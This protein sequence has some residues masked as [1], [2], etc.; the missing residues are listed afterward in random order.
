MHDAK[1]A[2]LADVFKRLLCESV[3]SE[4][5]D[6]RILARSILEL[7]GIIVKLRRENDA[8]RNK[9][10]AVNVCPSDY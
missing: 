3:P 9:L 2:A 7:V 5:D 4:D 10:D 1:L 8:L 6:S